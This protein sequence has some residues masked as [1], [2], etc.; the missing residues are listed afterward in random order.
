MVDAVNEKVVE[1]DVV[2]GNEIVEMEE[3]TV[4][5]ILDKR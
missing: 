3:E 4:Q 5:R 1:N 2:V